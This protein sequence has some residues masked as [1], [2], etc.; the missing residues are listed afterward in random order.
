MSVIRPPVPSPL[1]P[2]QTPPSPAAASR[3]SF[4]QSALAAASP[5]IAAAAPAITAP[6]V[7]RDTPVRSVAPRADAGEGGQR[8]SRPGSLLDIRV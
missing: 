4:F 1:F 2:S 3:S 6:V 5:S 7:Q 8:P